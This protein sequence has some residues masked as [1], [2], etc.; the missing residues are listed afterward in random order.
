MDRYQKLEIDK[1]DFSESGI[2]IQWSCPSLG[3]GC[4]TIY[5][6]NEKICIDEECMSAEFVIRVL[7]KALKK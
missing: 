7:E 1:I 6:K 5:I 2:R 4:L 3:F